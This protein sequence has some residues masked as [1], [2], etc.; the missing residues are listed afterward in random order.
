MDNH[1]IEAGVNPITVTASTENWTSGLTTVNVID[2]DR[3][4]TVT[5]PASGWEGQSL[6]GSIQLG[7]T[8]TSDLV[9]SLASSDPTQLGVPATVTI[10]AGQTSVTFNATL[11]DN[12]LHTGPQTEQVTAT[13]AGLPTA[14]SSVVVKDADVDHFVFSTISAL[15]TVGLPFSVT[16][17]ADDILNNVIQV[18]NGTATL[19][20][21]GSSGALP[22]SLT[23]ITFVGG[24]VDG[25]AQ[26]KCA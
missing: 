2:D 25:P 24:E 17:T 3:W 14:S 13:A 12:G 11:L 20:A 22:T 18:Y 7:G 6:S 8:L 5:L 1:V 26:R 19:T 16:I 4:M 15:Q 9:V 10:P 23:T 21:A